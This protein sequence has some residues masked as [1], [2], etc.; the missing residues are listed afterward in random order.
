MTYCWISFI[1][2]LSLSLWFILLVSLLHSLICVILSRSA[3]DR[4]YLKVKTEWF[5]CECAPAIYSSVWI[6][7]LC[8]YLMGSIRHQRWTFLSCCWSIISSRRSFRYWIQC[9]RSP[10][11]A[12]H[13]WVRMAIYKFHMLLCKALI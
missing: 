7:V 12:G 8:Q 10:W 9:W 11:G 5:E 1:L 3:E 13:Q 4:T 6:I 2:S